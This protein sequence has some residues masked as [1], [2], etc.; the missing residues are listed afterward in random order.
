MA[1]EYVL[2]GHWL[3]IARVLFKEIPTVKKELLFAAWTY[4]GCLYFFWNVVD[5]CTA[6]LPVYALFGG[7]GLS[8]WRFLQ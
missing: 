7:N 2:R 5:V 3:R 1:D 4:W 8:A 6:E